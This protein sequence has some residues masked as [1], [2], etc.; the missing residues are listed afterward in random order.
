MYCLLRRRGTLVAPLERRARLH[1]AAD[2]VEQ[3]VPC[4]ADRRVVF[5]QDAEGVFDL[6]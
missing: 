2:H 3:Q 6:G 5:V 4:E 1:G